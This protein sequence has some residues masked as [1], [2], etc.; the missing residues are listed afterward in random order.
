MLRLVRTSPEF[1][2]L[3]L[4]HTVSGA[5][6]AFNTVA[7]VVLVFDLTGSGVGVA[8]GVMFEVLPV[9]LLGPVA[10]HVADRVP[11]RRLLVVLADRWLGLGAAGYGLLLAAIG[12]GAA[13]GP[14]LLRRFIRAGDKRWIFGPYAVRGGVDLALAAFSSPVAA[15]GA[16]VAYGMSTST[17]TVAYQSTL[18]TAVPA[19]ARGVPSRS[20]TSSGTAPVSCPLPPGDC[21]RSSPT[22]GTCTSFPPCS[23]SWLPRSVS[24]S[25]SRGDSV[26]IG[27]SKGDTRTGCVRARIGGN[28]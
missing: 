21:C 9:L 5:G 11:R 3:F 13:S 10:G 22:C 6:D 23:C 7:I 14:L 18:Q 12:L 19:E 17:G 24:P 1:R 8:G 27:A 16:L 20:T 26:R 28:G 2:R 4:A 25:A 15:G